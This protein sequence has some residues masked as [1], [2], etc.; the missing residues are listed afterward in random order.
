MTMVRSL[1]AVLAL[2]VASTASAYQVTGPVDSVSDTSIVVVQEKGK[3]KGEKFEFA[4]D[5]GTKVSGD[6]KKGAKVTVEYTMTAKTVEVKAE[7]AAK[8]KKK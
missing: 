1:A 2:A 8:G 3:N 7:K 6:L 4:R 5:A